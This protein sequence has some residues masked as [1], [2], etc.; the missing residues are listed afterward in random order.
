MSKRSRRLAFLTSFWIAFVQVA[1]FLSALAPLAVSPAYA[2][3]P[4]QFL[5]TTIGSDADCI[6][7]DY[8]TDGVSA[9]GANPP[10]KSQIRQWGG[11]IG[12]A[13]GTAIGAIPLT[14]QQVGAKCDGSTDDAAALQSW[15]NMLGTVSISSSPVYA[16][17]LTGGT[18]IYKS[19]LSFTGQNAVS[20][21]GQ[22][23]N[24]N[25]RYAGTS[26]TVTGITWGTTNGGC[27][28]AGMQLEDFLMS[29]ATHMTAG[30]AMEF[31]D[32]CGVKMKNVLF[33]DNSG[34]AFGNWANGI[35]FKGGNQVSLISCLISGRVNA[36]LLAG[37][38]VAHG[39][40]ELTDPRIL[41]GI[42]IGAAVGLHAA[43][44]V[45]GLTVD[46]V[47]ILGNA[48]DV[49]LSQATVPIPNNQ[50][51]FGPT[52][53]IDATSGGSG[54]GIYVNDAGGASSILSMSGTWVASAAGN[55][56]HF[57]WGVSWLWNW[58][59]GWLVNCG[60]DGIVNYSSNLKGTVSN[61]FVSMHASGY[62]GGTG[63][64]FDCQIANYA[65]KF[66]NVTNL[67][68]NALG[69]YSSYCNATNALITVANGSGAA[70]P[71]GQA[72]QFTV[73]NTATLDGAN[74]T[75][76][77]GSCSLGTANPGTS[78]VSP[79]TTP[80][81]GKMSVSGGGGTYNVYNNTGATI[82][83]NVNSLIQ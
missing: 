21:K 27:S 51:F 8:V 68:A 3:C 76:G 52:A 71:G 83:V 45:G 18:C 48:I 70:I 73:R 77:M 1:G 53:F 28:M 11:A 40:S 14:P 61:I 17:T 30:A 38:D 78:W 63:Y 82:N 25:L 66:E 29:S 79:T 16:G 62:T 44:N 54:V 50:I 39:S 55:C 2:T 24:S 4:A 26:T 13:I 9:S 57:S 75:C 34:G 10:Q 72:T 42:I 37:D 33:E 6:F 35:I 67:D 65:L 31:D 81:A 12:S 36:I 7:R 49:E 64:N 23:A 69:Q 15:L 60:V 56:V 43:G 32:V 20:I 80:A 74:Y 5:S 59:G 41:G 22:G 58:N 47:D 46:G 19:G